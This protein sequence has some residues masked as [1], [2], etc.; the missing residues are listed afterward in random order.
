MPVLSNPGICTLIKLIKLL[1]GNFFH[2]PAFHFRAI[3]ASATISIAK[4]PISLFN[5]HQG[6]AV[7]VFAGSPAVGIGL[8]DEVGAIALPLQPELCSHFG[9]CISFVLVFFL[10]LH[11]DDIAQ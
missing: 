7:P 8:G 10:A 3:R 9:N 5:V 4:I 11:Q 6:T 2:V 1:P